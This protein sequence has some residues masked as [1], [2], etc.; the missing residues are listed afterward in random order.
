METGELLVAL[1]LALAL[2]LFYN[3]YQAVRRRQISAALENKRELE[4]QLDALRYEL[5][6][7]R[8]DLANERQRVD[9]LTQQLSAAGK[10]RGTFLDHMGYF[11]RTP[12]NLIIGYSELLLSGTYGELKDVQQARLVVIQRSGKDLLKYFT[13]M[14]DL[15][16]LEIGSVELQLRAVPVAPLIE[17][18]VAQAKDASQRDNVAIQQ[19][20]DETIGRIMGDEKR[21]E[22]V[23]THLVSNAIRFTHKGT[24]SVRAQQLNVRDGA[25]D[26]F[27]FPV[28]GWLKDGEWIVLSVS[29]TGIGI[30]SE[31]QAS[32][33]ETFYQVSRDQTEEQRGIGLGLAIAKRLIELHNGVIWVKS[34]EGS[35]STFHVALRAYR[36]L[37]ATDTQERLLLESARQR[38]QAG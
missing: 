10:S 6:N 1:G 17:R 9:A 3:V 25:A 20:V 15:H 24:V 18:V 31:A 30:P 19:E 28:R 23:M 13:D 12:L 36:D 16:R 8:S 11:I 14:L 37:R 32:I 35:G 33:F 38:S 5:R 21:I 27:N 7:V 22:Q 2:A 34:A 26:G 29:D 4:A